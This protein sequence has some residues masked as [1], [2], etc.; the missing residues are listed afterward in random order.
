[1]TTGLVHLY[2]SHRL[3]ELII[4]SISVLETIAPERNP[5]NDITQADEFNDSNDGL[6]R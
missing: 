6:A 2:L 3:L 4:C 1:V 5:N